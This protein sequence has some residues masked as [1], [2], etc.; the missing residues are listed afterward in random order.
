MTGCIFCAMM[1]GEIPVS[2][3]YENDCAIAIDDI[4]PVAKVHA[5]IITKTH[6]DNIL[7]ID[8]ENAAALSGIQRAIRE[9]AKIKGV[10]ESG[11]RLVSNCGADSGQSVPHLHFHLLGGQILGDKIL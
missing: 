8:G 1:D 11:F 5:L 4:N 9:V 6:Y 10:G 7:S 2:K 3:I